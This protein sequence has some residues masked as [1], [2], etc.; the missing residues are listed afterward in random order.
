MDAC[1]QC[2]H[3]N[4]C[5]KVISCLDHLN[6]P[7]IRTRQA[8]RLMTPE[9]ANACMSDLKTG[10][11][12][13]RITGGGK[14]GP[15]IVSLRKFRK[16]CSLYREWG[17]QADRLA[18]VNEKAADRLKGEPKRKLTRDLCLKGLHPMKG[19]NITIH[20]GR[21]QCLACRRIAA[22]NPPIHSILPFLDKIKDELRRGI[23]PG[24]ICRGARGRGTLDRR[25]ILV[26]SKRVL[27]LSSIEPGVRP[28]RLGGNR[29]QQ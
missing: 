26:R 15:A 8:P 7:F 17:A 12:I 24:Q 27:P 4:D 5:L 3:P 25:L 2:P 29:R 9:Q 19:E 6:A 16:H 11:T 14:F 28:I 21:R 1:S 13:R 20:K 10:R 23:S 18:K 22:A